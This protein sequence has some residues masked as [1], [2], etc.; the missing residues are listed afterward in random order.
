MCFGAN[1]VSTLSPNLCRVDS[2][3]YCWQLRLI[4]EMLLI[5]Q[6]YFARLLCMKFKTI[7]YLLVMTLSTATQA[8]EKQLPLCPSSPNCVSSQATDAD[9]FIVP[10]KITGNV[11][12]V[13]A[14]LKKSLV[15]QSRTVITNETDDTLH[16]EATSLVF[17]FVDDIDVVLDANARL[18]HIRSASRTGYSDFGVNRKRVE[19]LRAQLQQAHVIE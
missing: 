2:F 16:A 5:R 17:R 12:Q 7:F 10:F 9:H 8:S 1:Y 6:K 15:S 13:W 18:I 19:M 3:L 11:E 14:A 4:D